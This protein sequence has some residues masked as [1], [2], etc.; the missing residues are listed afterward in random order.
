L[1]K[2][3]KRFVVSL[4]GRRWASAVR[5]VASLVPILLLILAGMATPRPF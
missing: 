2:L 4:A 5:A 1:P 3:E